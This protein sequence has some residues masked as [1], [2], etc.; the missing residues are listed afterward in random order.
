MP[1]KVWLSE[2]INVW[3]F[4]YNYKQLILRYNPVFNDFNSDNNDGDDD[5][6]YNEDE[7]DDDIIIITL[8]KLRRPTKYN[9]KY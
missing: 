1:V 9:K 4:T 2:F 8:S 7:D 5:G 6:D 3:E